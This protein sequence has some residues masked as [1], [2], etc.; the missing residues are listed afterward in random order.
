MVKENLVNRWEPLKWGR[1]S[2]FSCGEAETLLRSPSSWGK[3]RS[4]NSDVRRGTFSGGGI[5]RAS[6]DR[7]SV[8]PSAS[9]GAGGGEEGALEQRPRAG[10]ELQELRRR[11]EGAGGSRIPGVGVPFDG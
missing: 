11:T 9:P 3:K 5:F 2:Y 7:S 8:F 1:D 6:A 4:N 10:G